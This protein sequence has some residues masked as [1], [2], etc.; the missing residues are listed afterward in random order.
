MRDFADKITWVV[1]A[2]GKKALYFRNEDTDIHPQLRTLSAAYIDNPPTREQGS[3]RPG[4]MND[5]SAG[6]ARK[7]SFESADWHQ[8]G[9]D[10]FAKAITENL[11]K[12]A[13]ADAFDHVVIFAPPKALGEM[14]THYHDELR[15]RIIAEVDRDLTGH[16]IEDIEVQTAKALKV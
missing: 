7:S 15:K 9:E 14:R 3:E 6:G 10:R 8:I 5:G 12:A 4:R 2:D 11:N 1:V 13:F 16:A